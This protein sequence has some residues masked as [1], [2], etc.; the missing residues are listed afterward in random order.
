VA[1]ALLAS[2]SGTVVAQGCDSPSLGALTGV[3][4]SQWEE[5]DAQ[6]RS[7]VRE[8]GTLNVAGLQAS[9]HCGT[10]DWTAQWTR[11]QGQ[12]AYD[13]VTT[14]QLPLQTQSQLRAQ[15]LTLAAW[16]PL[17]QGWAV[18]SQFGYRE[19]AREIASQGPVLGYPE[20]FTYLQLALGARYQAA[21]GER[22]HLTASGWLGGG[23]GGRV[24]VDL[25]RADP[26]TLSL[27]SHRLL[28]LSLQLGGGPA[29]R[30]GWSWQAGV[31]YRCE[32]TGAGTPEVIVRNGVP[33]GV[34]QQPRFVQQHL[35]ATA[36]ATYHF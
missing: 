28:E 31:A 29:A 3:E 8:R 2:L 1:G 12:R 24:R 22:V 16:L 34:A 18:G 30:L 33:V 19:V 26:V 17:S 11:S 27:G 23:P 6:G 14:T 20:R 25:P 36:V 21:L 9:G 7:L 13:G 4:R 35:L 15:A 5:F 32:L 10:G